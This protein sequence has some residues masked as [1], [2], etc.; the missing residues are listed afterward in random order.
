MFFQSGEKWLHP[1]KESS[2]KAQ[3]PGIFSLLFYSHFNLAV[4]LRPES[5]ICCMHKYLKLV[6]PNHHLLLVGGFWDGGWGSPGLLG[7]AEWLRGPAAL[8]RALQWH[9]SSEVPDLHVLAIEKMHQRCQFAIRNCSAFGG[10][11]AIGSKCIFMPGSIARAGSA[12]PIWPHLRFFPSLHSIS[13][14][15]LGAAL[16]C[17][18]AAEGQPWAQPRWRDGVR[19]EG[20]RAGT[21]WLL[22]LVGRW[23]LV[24]GVMESGRRLES[25]TVNTSNWTENKRCRIV[26]LITR[27]YHRLGRAGKA[28]IVSHPF[29][30][31]QTSGG[32]IS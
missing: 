23:C 29:N 10:M 20:A 24:L 2:G 1:L 22:E 21:C 3:V 25:A 26:S 12:V 15:G 14:A 13:L 9:W 30:M 6:P 28:C 5:F 18:G 11:P 19:G 7:A 31:E 4:F 17:C 32:Q 8:H 16:P 27:I